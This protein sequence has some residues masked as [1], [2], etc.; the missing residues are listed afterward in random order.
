MNLLFDRVYVINLKRRPD[1]LASIMNELAKHDILGAIPVEIIPGVDG[2]SEVNDEFLAANNYKIY[3]K[4]NDPWWGR[5]T[6]K[7]EIGC[8]I[9]HYK[10]WEKIKEGKETVLVIEDDIVFTQN[11]F[12]KTLEIA[13]EVHKLEFEFLYLGRRP[14]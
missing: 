13:P 6:T 9:T 10:I 7:G 12:N 14:I 8:G 5:S 1:K 3:D 11:F 4:W 2:Q